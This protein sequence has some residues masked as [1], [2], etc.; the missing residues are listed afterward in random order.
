MQIYSFVL[1]NLV[2]LVQILNPRTMKKF[3]TL[4]IALLFTGFLSAQETAA[5]KKAKAK[6]KVEQKTAEA[7]TDAKKATA[8]ADAK[9]K[10][11]QA[12]AKKDVAKAKDKAVTS[13]TEVKKEAKTA[14]KAS[15][16]FYN[17]KKVYTGPKGGKYYI[18]K[19]GNKTYIDQK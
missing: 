11:A 9:A 16:E 15:G 3:I 17:G 14:D 8:K 19:N 1:I 6:T 13:K 5:D 12:T 2:I 10:D 7:K 4:G 18:N